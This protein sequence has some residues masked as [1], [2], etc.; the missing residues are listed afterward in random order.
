[1]NIA[2]KEG[3]LTV[4]HKP[5][6]IYVK[7]SL[8]LPL[9]IIAFLFAVYGLI[10]I[11]NILDS[12]IATDRWGNI[13]TYKNEPFSYI[14]TLLVSVTISGVG[15]VLCFWALSSSKDKPQAENADK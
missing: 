8:L 9:K 7:S 10:G 12:G 5:R 15:F 6:K 4:F 1:M 2:N 3:T 14:S 11:Y 13:S